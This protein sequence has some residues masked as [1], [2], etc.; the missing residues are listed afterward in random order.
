[1]T[2]C[3]P[4]TWRNTGALFETLLL[5]NVL[6]HLIHSVDLWWSLWGVDVLIKATHH[7]NKATFGP[8]I[9]YFVGSRQGWIQNFPKRGIEAS[10][11]SAE[12][13]ASLA[14]SLSSSTSVHRLPSGFS[15]NFFKSIKEIKIPL[16]APGA[17]TGKRIP[18]SRPPLLH[19]H[20]TCSPAGADR[21][22]FDAPR[23]PSGIAGTA[24]AAGEGGRGKREEGLSLPSRD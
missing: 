19:V 7:Q 12:V 1:M 21:N 3:E 2:L 6:E 14:P 16:P 18:P 20:P 5:L 22:S 8:A 24:T 17:G 13:A 15:R 9:N 10:T 23:T 11:C 4:M